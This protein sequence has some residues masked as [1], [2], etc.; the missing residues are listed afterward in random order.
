MGAQD[1]QNTRV[2]VRTLAV[3]LCFCAYYV[4]TILFV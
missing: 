3:D 2:L 4:H 1:V